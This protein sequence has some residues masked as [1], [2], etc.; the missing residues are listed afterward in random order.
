M[1]DYRIVLDD[2]SKMVKG[3]V[4]EGMLCCSNPDC[5]AKYPIHN[6]IPC[7]LRCGNTVY[8]P[9]IMPPAP[10]LS[11]LDAHYARYCTPEPCSH[12]NTFWQTVSSAIQKPAHVNPDTA[13]DLG[14]ATGKFTFTLAGHCSI[15][16][17]L[18]T[19]F[20]ALACA[21]S[22]QRGEDIHFH[23]PIRAMAAETVKISFPAPENVLFI[24]GDALDPP[25]R[26]ESFQITAA[27]NLLDSITEPLILLKQMDALL[28]SGG[29]LLL[30]SPFAWRDTICDPSKWLENP[31]TPPGNMLRQILSGERIHDTD[32]QYTIQS[33]IRNIS[34]S[35]PVSGNQ[36]SLY[37][38]YLVKAIKN[39]NTAR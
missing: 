2:A 33:D 23:R 10:H 15:A 6:G 29:T 35:L 26:S 20:H 7:I 27:L 36:T 14:C 4:I 11:Y 38:T 17:G 9:S 13:I 1:T 28:E 8:P 30:T 22:L 12:N 19:D 5:K 25:F 21:A 31:E 34:W 3:Y 18:D 16:V 37:R 39:S 24:L 32:F